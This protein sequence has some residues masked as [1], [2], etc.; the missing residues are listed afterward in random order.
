MS[1]GLMAIAAAFVGIIIIYLFI[2][3]S[4]LLTNM[5]ILCLYFSLS[6]T[7]VE[8]MAEKAPDRMP[9]G[10]LVSLLLEMSLW[11]W[12]VRLRVCLTGQ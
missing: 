5:Y 12:S 4:S 3:I 1:Q 10:M 2:C 6:H 7:A 11:Q 9:M 8:E